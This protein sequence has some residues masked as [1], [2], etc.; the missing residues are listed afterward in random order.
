MTDVVP[1]R[2]ATV[3]IWSATGI[4]SAPVRRPED[5]LIR[6]STWNRYGEV[7]TLRA[8]GSS[9]E[10]FVTSLA[11]DGWLVRVR[12]H[13]M[14]KGAWTYSRTITRLCADGSLPTLAGG[15][16]WY[17]PDP[18][19]D[20]AGSVLLAEQIHFD[21]SAVA[22]S[23]WA[24]VTRSPF[25]S[26]FSAGVAA[27]DHVVTDTM[28][29]ALEF[30]AMSEEPAWSPELTRAAVDLTNELGVDRAVVTSP[31]QINARIALTHRRLK[32]Q[33][34]GNGSDEHGRVLGMVDDLGHEY[35]MSL[36]DRSVLRV[37]RRRGR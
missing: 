8:A 24:W 2:P 27:Y 36:P 33:R 11:D 26:G 31:N 1:L 19:T 13:G 23:A 32:F 7:A 20:L 5:L 37:K 10:A 9:R 30:V 25:P 12:H 3:P 18:T 34:R 29:E 6:V 21:P 22:Q 15:S 28:A 35:T 17:A 4:D 14:A 16:H